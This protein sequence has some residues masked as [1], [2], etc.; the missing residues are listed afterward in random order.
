MTP[1]EEA[2]ADMRYAK[3]LGE[4][5]LKQHYLIWRGATLPVGSED[6]EYAAAVMEIYDKLDTEDCLLKGA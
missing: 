5:A 6:A 4:T 2:I 3:G 1:R